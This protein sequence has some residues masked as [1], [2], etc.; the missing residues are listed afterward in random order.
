[1]KGLTLCQIP[2]RT[3]A[4]LVLGSAVR[5]RAGRENLPGTDKS[6]RAR[7]RAQAYNSMLRFG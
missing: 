5:N 7:K 1:M 2:Y 6:R 3:I 4:G